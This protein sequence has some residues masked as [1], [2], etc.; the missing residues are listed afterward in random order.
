[1]A[2]HTKKASYA[3]LEAVPPHLVAEIIGGVLMTHHHGTPRSAATRSGLSYVVSRFQARPGRLGGWRILHLPE[4]WLGG[5]V[6]VPDLC[7]WR[8]H[9]LPIL[10]EQHVTVVPDWVCEVISP[11]TVRRDRCAKRRLYAEYG[12]SHFWLID[13]E[14][15]TLE[16]FAAHDGEWLLKDAW[17]S[18]AEVRAPPFDAISFSLADLWPL[19]P[20]LGMNEDPTPYYAGDR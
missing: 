9:R 2:E 15:Q 13:P 10:P 8:A 11:E 14:A 7:G 6:V 3:D 12:V 1:M 4:L 19:D 5:D 18:D 20:P 17:N 16:A